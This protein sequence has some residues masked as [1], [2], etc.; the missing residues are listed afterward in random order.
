MK[1]AILFFSFVFVHA[2]TAAAPFVV[3]DPVD[4]AT[5]HCG[6]LLNVAPKLIVPVTTAGGVKNCRYDL[7]TLA[8]GSHTI[9]MTAIVEK[10]ANNTG[11]ESA[12]SSP[13]AFSKPGVPAVPA[14]L[15]LS[16]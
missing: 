15:A 13:L 2:I 1:R 11:A 14:G 7:A 12:P 3:T 16:P 9:T 5:T 10:T 6:V 4:P 8:S